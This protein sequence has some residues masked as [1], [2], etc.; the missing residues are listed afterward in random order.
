MRLSQVTETTKR[1][2]F[3]LLADDRSYYLFNYVS[4]SGPNA[5][6]TNQLIAHLKSKPGEPGYRW[7]RDAIAQCALHLREALGPDLIQSS[8]FV[9]TP[10]S[11][12][13]DHPEYDDRVERICRGIAREADVRVLVRQSASLPASHES[14]SS[15]R[16]SVEILTRLYT[17]DEQ[18][19]EPLPDK[20]V[21]VDDVL[22]TGAHY[23]A[24]HNV[25]SERFPSVPVI[26]VFIARR[27]FPNK[28]KKSD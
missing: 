1:A 24:M 10:P 6:T 5:S 21:V 18:F 7:K 25:L 9:P 4:H 20:L 27:S 12:A 14:K 22:T 16:T 19:A 8:T 23:R 2:H 17:V 28:A 3:R 11:K 13:P 26:G 15:K